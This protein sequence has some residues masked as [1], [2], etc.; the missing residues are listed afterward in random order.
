M[1]RSDSVV[2]GLFLALGLLLI[3]SGLAFPPG[4]GG[5]PGA[6]FFPKA[7]GVLMSLLAL[8]LLIK[9]TEAP[10]KGPGWV[11]NRQ[12]VAGTAA[13]LCGY[14]LLWGTGL[15]PARTA[16]FLLLTLR[17]LGQ[18]WLEAA[19]YSAA[20]TAFVY[21]AFDMGLNVSLD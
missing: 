16:I 17:F 5:L 12:Q 9:R 18:R 14:L 13:L 7:I 8:G 3:V 19:G 11:A 20:L 21:L 4:V 2:A 10:S 1:S 6:G 15:F